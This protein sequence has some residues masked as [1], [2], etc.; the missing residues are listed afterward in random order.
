MRPAAVTPAAVVKPETL[1]VAN[2][3]EP[4]APDPLH[5]ITL[6]QIRH[7]VQDGTAVLLDVRSP[8]SFAR[9]HVRGALN[10][11]PGPREAM[12]A[13]LARIRDS[14]APDQLFILYCADLSC[15]SSDMACEYL[16]DEGFTNMR[17]YSP[18]WRVLA[19]A[20]DLQ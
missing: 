10:L 6:D 11:P 2:R 16:A 4:P 8:E 17:V 13:D 1:L 5:D 14:F 20:A 7:H 15:G 9:G 19:T 3:V 12:E 18:G